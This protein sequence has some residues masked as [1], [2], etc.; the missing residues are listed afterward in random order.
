MAFIITNHPASVP[1]PRPVFVIC[2]S[3]MAYVFPPAWIKRVYELF[4]M[5]FI[6]YYPEKILLNIIFQALMIR[7]QLELFIF[8]TYFSAVVPLTSFLSYKQHSQ[9]V[10]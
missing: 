9:Q 3:S 2:F 5:S 8:I 7:F 10:L 1:G 6:I 4:C